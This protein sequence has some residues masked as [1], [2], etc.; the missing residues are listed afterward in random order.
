MLTM[1]EQRPVFPTIEGWARYV[2]L[3]AGAIRECDEHRNR[4][5]PH[6]RERAIH[7]ARENPLFAQ[8][9]VTVVI[10][11]RVHRTQFA[12]R[13]RLWHRPESIDRVRKAAGKVLC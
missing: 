5:D 10:G 11:Y 4:G 3:E 6:A 1:K 9:C 8:P 13:G 12:W 2:L 7:Y